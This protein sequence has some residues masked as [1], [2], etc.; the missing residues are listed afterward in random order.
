M[1]KTAGLILLI[2][3][4]FQI[5]ACS[6]E[7]GNIELDTIDKK[8]SYTMGYEAVGAIS[9]L[10]SV[11]IDEE[12]FIEGI[13]DAFGSG[14]PQL[15]QQQ[16]L[17]TK[18]MVFDNERIHLNQQIIKGAGKNLLSQNDFLEKNKSRE[19]VTATESGLQYTILEKGDGPLPLPGDYARIL[20]RAKLLNGTQ[21]KIL[22]TTE[23]PTFV[24]VIGNLFFWEKA[25]TLMP[26]GSRF[27]FFVPSALAYGE[28]G[29][30]IDGGL[31]G[32]N[33][34]IIIDIDLLEVKKSADFRTG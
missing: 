33:Q 31:V 34:L 6:G 2:G 3:F 9:N 23:I 15:T 13:R 1:Q 20:S 28:T 32:P 27:R 22:S 4:S 8:F 14:P 18:A 26:T 11:T 19:G 10:T 30:F 24:P 17:D 7:K 21:I 16:G 12:A 5:I 29:N 25:L